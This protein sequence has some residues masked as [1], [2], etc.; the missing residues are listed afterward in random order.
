MT[1]EE[2]QKEIISE[3]KVFDDWFGRH[4]HL[5]ELGKSLPPLAPEYKTEN[6]LVKG[7]QVKTWFHSAAKDGKMF[8]SI[9]SESALIRGIISLLARIFSGQTPEEIKNADLFFVDKVG[10]EEDFS[11]MRANSVFK[12]ASR[13]KADAAAARGAGGT[14]QN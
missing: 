5:I 9:D 3:F 10:L 7:C 11:P 13:I 2:T 8:Y 12:I 14:G 4:G 1:I 6:N